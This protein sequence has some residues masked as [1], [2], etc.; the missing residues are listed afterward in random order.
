MFSNKR[1]LSLLLTI[2]MTGSLF[3]GSCK[4]A[5]AASPSDLYDK[6]EDVPKSLVINGQTQ[7]LTSIEEILDKNDTEDLQVIINHPFKYNISKPHKI[8]KVKNDNFV[9]PE[10]E[11]NLRWNTVVSDLNDNILPYDSVWI[12]NYKIEMAVISSSG[13]MKWDNGALKMNGKDIIPYEVNGCIPNQ[14]A[15]ISGGQAITSAWENPIWGFNP[16]KEF[17]DNIFTQPTTIS[18]GRGVYKF[19]E[20]ENKNVEF[21]LYK[22]N[23]GNEYR[24][25]NVSDPSVGIVPPNSNKVVYPQSIPESS[26]QNG[27]EGTTNQIFRYAKVK[28]RGVYDGSGNPGGGTGGGDITF[29]P[30]ETSWTNQGKTSNGNGDYPV[31]V[32]YEG[33]NPVVLQGTASVHHSEP[34]APL[35][36]AEAG[37]SPIPQPNIEF[38]YTIPFD[39]KFK[40]QSI[41]VSGAA[42]D[43]INGTSGTVHIRKQGKNLQLNAVG[44]WASPEYTLPGVGAFESIT[45]TSLPSQPSAPSGASGY[46]N[47]DWTDPVLSIDEPGGWSKYPLNVTLTANDQT[48]LSGVK[49]ATYAAT[50]NSHYSYNNQSG[51]FNGTKVITLNEGMFTIKTD[52]EDNAG[53]TATMTKSEFKID[54][55]PP[56]VDSISQAA[57]KWFNNNRNTRTTYNLKFTLRE[58]L[59][60]FNNTLISFNDRSYYKRDHS[61]SLTKGIARYSDDLQG[62]NYDLPDGI[63]SLTINHK[64]LAGNTGISKYGEY[65]VDTT[66]PDVQFSVPDN[67]IF[68]TEKGSVRIG[69]QYYGKITYTDN[70]SGV[71]KTKVF[72]KWTFGPNADNTEDSLE[73]YTSFNFTDPVNPAKD[74]RHDEVITELIPKPVGDNMYLHIKMWD[75]SG[76]YFYKRFGAFSDPIKLKNFRVTDVRDPAFDEI[77][78]NKTYQNHTGYYYDASKLPID[79]DSN[80]KHVGNYPKKGYSFYFDVTSEY[81][82]RETDRIEIKPTWYWYD[83]KD[84]NSKIPVDMYYQSNGNPIAAVGGKDDKL[85]FN[86]NVDGK[87]SMIGT[88]SKLTLY[89]D[90]R[91]HQYGKDFASWKDTIQYQFGKEQYWYGKYFIPH[92]A[93]FVRKGDMPLP[94]KLIE[95]GCILINFEIIGYKNGAETFSEDQTFKYIPDQ[96]KLEG[97]PR[98]SFAEGDVIIYNNAKSLMD[99]YRS[100]VIK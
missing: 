90:V 99:D 15:Y 62:Y 1:L 66:D 78:W 86:M 60:G 76:N 11:G 94:N 64:D 85:T 7:L 96:W 91:I 5:F 58:N 10:T 61:E 87:N 95:N 41:T 46:Y 93:K 51:S 30:Y 13:A 68:Y 28:Y 18:N 56:R 42:N 52:V 3:I 4:E 71:D 43:T 34:Q 35:P 21:V 32:A 36:P 38:D 17:K 25:P 50:D 16:P 97:G 20:K 98:A 12:K 24:L 65:C 40:L 39:V 54:T 67:S 75:I 29:T 77:F 9:D 26:I 19:F 55:T 100:N 92:S 6:K 70:L 31:R 8:W 84:I 59:S 23:Q 80:F 48:E 81:L 82:Y 73:G 2:T 88:L 53:N 79:G 14:T 33:D 45:S 49:S 89:K 27:M 22:P 57:V 72:Y 83:G 44:S 69:D 37:G 47:L 63:Y 74:D